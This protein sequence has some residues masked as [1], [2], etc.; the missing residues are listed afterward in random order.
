[1]TDPE[2]NLRVVRGAIEA[3]LRGDEATMMA[4]TSPEVVATQFPDQLDVGDYRG[5]AELQR[6]MTEWVGSW[7][8]WTIEPVSFEV[9][10]ERVFVNAV[11]RGRGRESGAPMESG[12]TFVFTV[13]D[14]L[15][16]RWQMFHTEQEA[17]EA[18]G[19]DE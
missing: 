7:E 1:M 16:A 9:A 13:R 19:G 14:G 15:I 18:A 12:V 11:Q 3:Y 5:R 2:E 17:R 10:D 6:M 4:F 8:D